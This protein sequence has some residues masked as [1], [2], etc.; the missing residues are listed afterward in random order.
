MPHEATPLRLKRR[1]NGEG[2]ITQRKDGRPQAAV[3]GLDGRRRFHYGATREDVAGNLVDAQKAVGDADAARRA[4]HTGRL[5]RLLDVRITGPL[6]HRRSTWVSYESYVRLHL[7]PA[8]GRVPLAYPTPAHVQK[9]MA[10]KLRAAASLESCAS[11]ASSC[12]RP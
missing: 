5:P 2:T 8:L 3:Y 10:E 12:E 7:K 4:R 9:F 1:A 6:V 11:A